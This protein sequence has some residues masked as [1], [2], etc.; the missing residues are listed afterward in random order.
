MPLKLL[1]W[2]FI[3]SEMACAPAGRQTEVEPARGVLGGDSFLAMDASTGMIDQ[4]PDAA[5]PNCKRLNIGILGKLGNTTSSNFQTWLTNA[6]TSAKNIETTPTDL[7]TASVLAEFD[8]IVLDELQHDYSSSEVTAFQAWVNAGGGFVSMSGFSGASD[9]FRANALLAPMGL[10][11]SG[12]IVNGPVTTFVPS[13][14]TAGLTSVSFVGG[15]VIS[16]LGGTATT[17]TPI[18]SLP[19]GNVGYLV[20]AG[21]GG[22]FVWGDE[23]IEYDSEWQSIPDIKQL[24]VNVFAWIGPKNGCMLQPI[25]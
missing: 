9:D 18:A 6:G 3:F 22:G 17:R 5:M 4:V 25:Q 15:Y 21:Q 8:V 14:V 24:W 16:D 7:L 1:S 11:Y 23:W 12:S 13:A 20:K 10:A 2:L 19:A